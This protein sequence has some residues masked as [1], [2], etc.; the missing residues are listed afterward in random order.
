VVLPPSG[1]SAAQRIVAFLAMLVLVIAC[2]IAVIAWRR[3]AW[4]GLET[5]PPS[6][7]P[8]PTR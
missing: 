3:P 1:P 8:S 7:S 2:G 4:V 6:P 5:S